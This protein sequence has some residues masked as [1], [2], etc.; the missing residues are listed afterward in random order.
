MSFYINFNYSLLV[1]SS[2]EMA[3]TYL[4]SQYF[5]FVNLYEAYR[6]IQ[7]KYLL[8]SVL[9]DITKK[10]QKNYTEKGNNI[11]HIL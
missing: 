7:L 6:F 4:Y 5:Y 11:V 3:E 10:R 9:S 8:H 2:L 1:A